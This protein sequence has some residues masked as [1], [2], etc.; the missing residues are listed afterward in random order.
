M[1]GTLAEFTLTHLLQLFALSEKMGTTTV[2]AGTLHTRMLLESDRVVGFG[3]AD[4]DVRAELAKLALLST[5]ARNALNAVEPRED[6]P[7]LSLLS[8]N[9]I[10]PRRWNLYVARCFEQDI[11]PLLNE[12]DGA[13]EITV[14]GAV[15]AR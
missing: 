14:E 12:D 4:F 3:A 10:E 11:Y 6:T 13:F 7:G 9:L 8:G 2:H 5:I 15:P 1:L